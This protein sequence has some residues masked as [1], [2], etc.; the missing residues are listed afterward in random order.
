MGLNRNIPRAAIAFLSAAF[1]LG[2]SPANPVAELSANIQAGR[3]E[4]KFDDAQ[5]YLRS[6]LEAL[7]IPIE[8][9]M[10]VFSKTSVQALRIE[11]A[12]PVPFSSTIRSSSAGCAADL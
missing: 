7:H 9:Q 4:L 6:L 5:G 10:V 2:Q 1:A 12:A 8:S 3:V 11:P